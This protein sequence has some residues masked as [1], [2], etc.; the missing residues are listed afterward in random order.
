MIKDKMGRRDQGPKRQSIEDWLQLHIT[1]IQHAKELKT[2]L[3][4]ADE[5]SIAQAFIEDCEDICPLLYNTYGHQVI[6]GSDE[7][8]MT[9]LI[10]EFNLL[11]KPKPSGR[12][13]HATLSGLPTTGEPESTK[14]TKPA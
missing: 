5:R 7:V 8:S 9:K 4:G 10:S 1:I 11:Y 14:E 3:P 13:A 12:H 2:P 6:T